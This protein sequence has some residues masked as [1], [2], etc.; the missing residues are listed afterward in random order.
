[1]CLGSLHKDQKNNGTVISINLESS[2]MMFPEM[3]EFTFVADLGFFHS[4]VGF[5]YCYNGFSPSHHISAASTS[6]D[7]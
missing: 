7:I 1:M 2:K 3:L 6:P 4:S 5:Y